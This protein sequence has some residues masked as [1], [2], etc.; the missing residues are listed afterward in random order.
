MVSWYIAGAVIFFTF[1]IVMFK[2]AQKAWHK[3]IPLIVAVVLLLLCIPLYLGWFGMTG[4][5]I[6]A[7]VLLAIILGFVM[8]SA[9]GAV[10]LAWLVYGVY[11]YIKKRRA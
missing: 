10:A 7:N 2:K 1:Q 4:G 5:F 3:F 8:L 11:T 6:Q 9:I